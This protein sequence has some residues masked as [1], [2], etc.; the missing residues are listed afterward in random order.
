MVTA[1]SP[2]RNTLKE[3]F[4]RWLVELG[5]LTQYGARKGT[6]VRPAMAARN[7]GAP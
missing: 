3:H 6:L 5:H 2:S 4:R 7:G 1:T